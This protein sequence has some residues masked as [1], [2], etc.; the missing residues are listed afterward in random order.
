MEPGPLSFPVDASAEP[1]HIRDVWLAHF[2]PPWDGPI[3]APEFLQRATTMIGEPT[4]IEDLFPT[5]GAVLNGHRHRHPA[6]TTIGLLIAAS[7]LVLLG[8]RLLRWADRN[9]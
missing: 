9:L 4:R 8:T 5:A 2:L 1:L 3:L 7:V 6:V